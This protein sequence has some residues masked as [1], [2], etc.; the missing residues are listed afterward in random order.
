MKTKKL[1]VLG[2]G[3]AGALS[4]IHFHRW[5]G[6]HAEIEWHY[7]PNIPTQAVGEGAPLNLPVNLV[8]NIGFT[9]SDL[10]KIDGT[11]KAGIFKDGWGKIGT[12]FT[13]N[14]HGCSMSYHFNAIALQDYILQH[15]KSRIKIVEH[16]TSSKDIDAD[17]V[18]DCA[19]KP[20]DFEDY[21]MSKV[22]PVNSVYV[23]QCY[24][25]MPRFNVTLTIA[26]PY[27]WVFGIPL[28]NR[29]SIGYMYNSDFNNLEEIKE[30]VKNI[31]SQYQ[32]NPSPVTNSFS[33]KNYIKKNI[34]TLDGKKGITYNGN[35]CFFL[36]PL[37]ATSIACMDHINRESFDFWI[38]KSS[39]EHA[40]S[41]TFKFIKDCE[42]IIAI[43]YFA[44]SKYKTPF[45][46][47]AKQNA[48]IYLDPFIKYD[49]NFKRIMRIIKSYPLEKLHDPEEKL[50]SSVKAVGPFWIGSW[51][52]NIYG[53]QLTHLYE[54]E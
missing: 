14:F 12:P 17:F 11:L 23:T 31:F 4:V 13:H 24:W 32:L 9:H 1:A 54:N 53:L 45:W 35:A 21:Y 50:N 37:E 16:N 2:R 48:E 15:M 6:D 39:K 27:G 52:E 34:V 28:R 3:T 20:S 8:N 40:N 41:N 36:E 51:K 22:V 26:R 49:D 7:D 25:D 19:G 29:C 33:F 43:H 47:N 10:P 42:L 5:L 44:G 18:M 30:D 38:A 46:K